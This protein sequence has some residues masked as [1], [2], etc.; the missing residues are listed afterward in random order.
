M[1]KWPQVRVSVWLGCRTEVQTA[2]IPGLDDLLAQV[3]AEI[4]DLARPIECRPASTE[5][6]YRI[7][8][9]ARV[10][11]PAALAR[12][13]RRLAAHIQLCLG[14]RDGRVDVLSTAIS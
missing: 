9:E 7:M 14:C 11:P 12:H 2:S 5:P 10:T 8:I 13:A 4:P 3:Q 1:R 6:A